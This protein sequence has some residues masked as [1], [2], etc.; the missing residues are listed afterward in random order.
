VVRRWVKSGDEVELAE[1]VLRFRGD[2]DV[3]LL[4]LGKLGTVLVVVAAGVAALWADRFHF[5]NRIMAVRNGNA[6][7]TW[8]ELSLQPHGGSERAMRH[9]T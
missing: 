8:L 5:R 6:C 9:P 4:D 3:V 7:G 1:V 2:L